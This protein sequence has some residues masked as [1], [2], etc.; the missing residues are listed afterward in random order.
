MKG[1]S[2]IGR[3]IG[4][5]F[6]DAMEIQCRRQCVRDNINFLRNQRMIKEELRLL[7]EETHR[8]FQQME[9]RILNLQVK[10]GL[11]HMLQD[12]NGTYVNVDNLHDGIEK[13]KTEVSTEVLCR[14]DNVKVVST[15]DSTIQSRGLPKT[16]FKGKCSKCDQRGHMRKQCPNK[17]KE[18]GLDNK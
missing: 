14:T 4:R 7:R 12:Y 13:R 2:E 11:P 3:D 5:L 6:V 17:L 8:Q 15:L 10:D 18:V 9:E 1:L 16:S